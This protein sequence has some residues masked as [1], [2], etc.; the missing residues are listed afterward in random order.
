MENKYLEELKKTFNNCADVKFRQLNREEGSI[1]I[2][3][4]D[5][6]CDSRFINEFIIAPLLDRNVRCN[7]IN[8]I[9]NEIL[10]TNLLGSINNLQEATKNILEGN[11]VL[12]FT[13][14]NEAV[15]CESKRSVRRQIS[16]PDSETTTKGPKDSFNENIAD[17]ISLIRQRVQNVNLKN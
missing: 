1:Y 16:Y 5:N 3:F 7:D 17:N 14:I 13:F 12:I 2:I 9:K 15:Y 10:I 8:T 4:I 11:V 6:M